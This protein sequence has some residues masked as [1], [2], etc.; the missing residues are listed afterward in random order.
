MGGLMKLFRSD[1]GLSSISRKLTYVF[2][3][4]SNSYKI[5]P[6][7]KHAKERLNT[8]TRAELR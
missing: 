3:I 8:K 6:P 5:L 1:L 2:K 7:I 4:E